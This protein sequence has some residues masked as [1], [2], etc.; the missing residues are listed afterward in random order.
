MSLPSIQ[1]L[2]TI[3]SV[4]TDD[5][6]LDDMGTAE[7]EVIATGT[8]NKRRVN[9]RRRGWTVVV[10]GNIWKCIA[11]ELLASRTVGRVAQFTGAMLQLI[12]L[13]NY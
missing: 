6:L 1:S 11:M 7:P 3:P 2:P 10:G 12:H 4:D 13:L 5:I 9:R 8:S